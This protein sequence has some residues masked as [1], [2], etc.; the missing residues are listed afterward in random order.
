MRND[1]NDPLKTTSTSD[2]A[3]AYFGDVRSQKW[4]LRTPKS[5]VQK[6]SSKSEGRIPTDD[7]TGQNASRKPSDTGHRYNLSK[8][9]LVSK[10]F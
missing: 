1:Q 9:N 7:S 6:W 10:V 2:F 4:R 3:S 8:I 5:G